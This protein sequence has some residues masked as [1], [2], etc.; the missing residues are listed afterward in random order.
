MSGIVGL[1]SDVAGSLSHASSYPEQGPQLTGIGQ[2]HHGSYIKPPQNP[3]I[4]QNANGGHHVADETGFQTANGRIQQSWMVDFVGYSPNDHGQFQFVFASTQIRTSG[5]GKFFAAQQMWGLSRMNR[6]L[7]KD[8]W[9]K[10]YGTE[11]TY[12][13]LME[14]FV[15]AGMRQTMDHSPEKNRT[16]GTL[17]IWM[18]KRAN[19][20]P[21][22]FGHR[23]RQGDYLF[24]LVRRVKRKD[25]LIEIFNDAVVQR[26]RQRR[27]NMTEFDRMVEEQREAIELKHKGD[28]SYCWQFIPCFGKTS[29][30]SPPEHLY[31]DRRDGSVGTYLFIGTV[32][33][34]QG[35]LSDRVDPNVNATKKA[36]ALKAVYPED[37]GATYLDSLMAGGLTRLEVDLRVA[38]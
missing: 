31:C 27:D 4:F 17:N 8:V 24:I 15:W 35:Q 10:K 6:N 20:V 5:T 1:P 38:Y 30:I 18:A 36:I 37:D 11:K 32:N 22:I 3:N 12:H 7:M 9:V 13:K 25:R 33:S 2:P 14:D 28:E 23:V 19:Q 29:L 34:I 21:N 26:K 16:E